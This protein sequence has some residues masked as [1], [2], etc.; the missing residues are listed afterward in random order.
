MLIASV[1]VIT[2]PVT[3]SAVFLLTKPPAIE[4]VPNKNWGRR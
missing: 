2:G 4:L 3:V 1:R